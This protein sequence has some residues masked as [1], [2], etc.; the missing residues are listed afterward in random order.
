MSTRTKLFLS[1]LAC[2]LCIVIV[3]STDT[4]HRPFERMS[5]DDITSFDIETSV[6]VAVTVTGPDE[7][8]TLAD[9]LKR[10]TILQ[11]VDVEGDILAS[12]SIFTKDGKSYH[13]AVYDGYIRL[14]GVTCS[15]DAAHTNEL[16]EFAKRFA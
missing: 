9:M 3:L 7:R 13:L 8:R 16:F 14:D 5:P 15:T 2:I 12:Y 1:A 4:T 11:N 6:G 10:L